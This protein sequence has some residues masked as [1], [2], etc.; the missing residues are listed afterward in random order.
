MAVHRLNIDS[1][2]K[3]DYILKRK[4]NLLH[5]IYNLG[6]FMFLIFCLFSYF[7]YCF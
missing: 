5:I 7:Y 2:I 4:F 1:K 3:I 6:T